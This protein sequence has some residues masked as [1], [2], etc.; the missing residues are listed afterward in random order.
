MYQVLSSENWTTILYNSTVFTVDPYTAW[1]SGAFFILWFVLANFIV[2]NMFIAVV[3]ENFEMSEDI[4]R[5]HQ[6]RT[7]IQQKEYY[8]SAALEMFLGGAVI[9]NFFG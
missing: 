2:L 5:L 9:E 1:I 6:V 7:F 8:G 3:Q 4:K